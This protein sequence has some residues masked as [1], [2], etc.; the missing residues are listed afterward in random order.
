MEFFLNVEKI[1]VLQIIIQV[2]SCKTTCKK[3]K[4][5]LK[6]YILQIKLTTYVGGGKGAVHG[7]HINFGP[8]KDPMVVFKKM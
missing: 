4:K 3:K 6:S 5:K 1:R 7:H 2:A 8:Q